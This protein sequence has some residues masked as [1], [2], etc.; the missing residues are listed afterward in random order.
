MKLKYCVQQFIFNNEIGYPLNY[1][2]IDHNYKLCIIIF[3]NFS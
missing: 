3:V 2:P 1:E